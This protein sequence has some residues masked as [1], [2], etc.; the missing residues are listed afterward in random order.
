[1]EK[2]KLILLEKEKSLIML[3]LIFLLLDVVTGVTLRYFRLPLYW[4]EEA[5]RYLFVWLVML[6][7][8]VGVEEKTHFSIDAFFKLF[9]KRLQ[10]LVIILGTIVSGIFLVVLLL[11]LH[12]LH[13]H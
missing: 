9:P 13:T 12:L 10:R 2:I 4:T 7:C 3:I 6:G 8:I 1:M 11:A 5:A